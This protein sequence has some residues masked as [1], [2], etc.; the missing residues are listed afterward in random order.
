MSRCC[1]RRQEYKPGQKATVKV[2]LTDF[3]G[4]PFV[5][6]TVLTDLRQERRVHLRR[7]ERA[8]DQG[9]LLEV[10]AASLP[11]DR[12]EPGPLVR[13]PAAQRRDRHGQPRRLRRTVVEELAKRRRRAAAL[14][15]DGKG[16]GGH[17]V[18]RRNSRRSRRAAAPAMANGRSAGSWRRPRGNAGDEPAAGD[19]Q[20]EP[21][22]SPTLGG[23]ADGPQE[24]RRHR[25][26]GRRP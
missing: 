1:R 21:P 26:L 18:E 6:S 14:Q 17:S 8:G 25:L 9:V 11:A 23:P 15:M 10:A 4:K 13:Q 22:P 24:L 19:K 20:G 16:R 7:L 12:V 3:V 2:K 5:G